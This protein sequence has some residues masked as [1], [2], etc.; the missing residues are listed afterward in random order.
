[1]MSPLDTH[2]VFFGGAF[3]ASALEAVARLADAG[4]EVVACDHDPREVTALEAAAIPLVSSRMQALQGADVVITSCQDPEA[5]EE[6]YLGENGLLELMEPHTTAIDL[7]VSRPQLAREI[8]A[9]A[10]ISELNTVDCPLVNFGEREQ[11][12]A[13]VGGDPAA[14][15]G[16]Q[17]LLPY[18]ATTIHMQTAPGEGQ[19]AAVVSTIGLA[20]SLMG[21]VEAVSIARIAGLSEHSTLDALASTSAAS[22]A[23]VDYAPRIMGYDFTGRIMVAEFLE[24]LETAVEVADD[25]DVT[26][27][28]VETAHQ[29]C[30]LLSVVGGGELNV[31]ALALL[32]EDE[33]TCAE[34][35]L[36]WALADQL[37]HG[38]PCEGMPGCGD[39]IDGFDMGFGFGAGDDA[40]PG[41]PGGC[42]GAG[43]FPYPPLGGF[44][45]KN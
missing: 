7:S 9:M 25:L 1:M 39:D 3:N 19:L 33:K 14:I 4:Y 13:F 26:L 23:L 36:D 21:M 34:H 5:V 12:V 30:D 45:S 38:Y 15:T 27:P 17:P 31:H 29:L 24:M 20:G 16:I 6:L 40:A 43:G 44:F 41:H 35:G 2:I 32:Y 28:M 8:Q 11:T 22:R 42:P 10:A 18:L 37:Y